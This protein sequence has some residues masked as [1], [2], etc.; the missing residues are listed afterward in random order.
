MITIDEARF[1][2]Y[3][4]NPGGFI[5]TYIFP[6]GMLPTR[7]H[8]REHAAEAGLNPGR[9]IAFG[10]DYAD[11]LAHWDCAFARQTAWLEAHGY[12][13][14]FRRMWRYY[15][16]FCEAGF[17]AGQIDVVQTVLHKP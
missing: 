8:L 17:R 7:R 12:D 6:G 9:E 11:T 4:A 16:A 3:A 1:D 13:Q 14:R 15:L 5:Q 2:A 10:V